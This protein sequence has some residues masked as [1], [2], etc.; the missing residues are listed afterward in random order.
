MKVLSI[1]EPFA[2][3]I[4]DGIKTVETRSFKTN[5][6]GELY[7]HASLNKWKNDERNL[8]GELSSEIMPGY[9]LCKCKLVDCVYMTKEYVNEMK[10]N[11]PI[12]YKCGLYEEGRYAWI[13]D[14]VEVIDPIKANGQLGIWNYYE[15]NEVMEIMD[16]VDYGWVDKNKNKHPEVDDLFENNYCLQSPKELL[17]SKLGVCWDQVELERYFFKSRDIKTYFICYYDNEGCPSHTFLV[18]KEK[19]NYYWFEHSWYN[20]KGIHKYNTLEE[21]LFDVRKKFIIDN[22]LEDED[23]DNLGLREYSKPKYNL[24]SKDFFVHCEKKDPIILD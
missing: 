7:I 2:S 17:K 16:D 9:I 12:E 3:L 13:L 15:M 24:S 22:N 10:V 21:L 1:R 8:Y 18:L 14:D 23:L 5:Y 6:R 20:Y 11:N 19:D 4:K